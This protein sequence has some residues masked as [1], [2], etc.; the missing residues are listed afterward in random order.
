M[1]AARSGCPVFSRQ[2]LDCACQL[3]LLSKLAAYRAAQFTGRAKLQ[4]RKARGTKAAFKSLPTATGGIARAAHA[5]AI[6]A[7]VDVEP[8]L[9]RAGLTDREVKNPAARMAVSKQIKFLNLAA[10]ALRDDF[11]G[12][13]LAQSLDLRELGLLYYVQASSATLTEALRRV[14]RYSSIMNDG[15][16]ITCRERTDVSLIFEYRGVSRLDDR[17][18]IEFFVTTVLRLCRQLVG[19]RLSPSRVKLV[20]RRTQLPRAVKILFGCDVVFGSDSDE[21]IFPQLAKSLPIANAD[22]FLNSL[23]VK[24][25]DEALSQRRGRAGTWRLRVENAIAPLLPHGQADMPGVAQRLGMSQR[26]LARRL[27]S[28]GLKFVEVVDSLRFDLAK[29]Y[30]REPDV[31]IAQVAWLL[32][33]R[34]SSAFN[35]AF[36]RWT[37]KSPKQV[38][39]SRRRAR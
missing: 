2:K 26:T 16:H 14:A 30:L 21:M 4:G 19:R 15:V 36:K 31:Q 8:L 6:E 27:D 20:H 5:R 1:G 3:Q 34:E 24:Y 37:G 32:G 28:E 25:C 12:V 13:R 11:L 22:P 29:R 35:H 23:L 9:K 39:A 17:H 10:N 18:Q 38:R 33:Y 7:G